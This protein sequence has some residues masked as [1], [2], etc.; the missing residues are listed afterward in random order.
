M[1]NKFEIYKD[2]AGEFRWR[3]K[4]KNGETIAISSEGYTS[5]QN[6]QYSVALV[7]D[8]KDAVVDD[9]TK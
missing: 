3:F 1:A 4:A 2:N 7:Q 6:C 9:L 8:S 5:K